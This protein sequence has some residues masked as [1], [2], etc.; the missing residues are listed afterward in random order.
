MASLF[1]TFHERMLKTT[2]I[3]K[4]CP[5]GCIIPSNANILQKNFLFN[6]FHNALYPKRLFFVFTIYADVY[7]SSSLIF[8]VFWKFVFLWKGRIYVMRYCMRLFQLH[9]IFSSRG[10]LITKSESFNEMKESSP[11]KLQ[12]SACTTHSI[13][14]NSLHFYQLPLYFVRMAFSDCCNKFVAWARLSRSWMLITLFAFWFLPTGDGAQSEWALLS[15]KQ[16]QQG[17]LL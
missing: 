8:V 11:K 10:C 16:L 6:N 4:E 13:C 7:W 2:L 3:Q 12:L 15:T 17:I 1:C 9:W 5:A 14:Q